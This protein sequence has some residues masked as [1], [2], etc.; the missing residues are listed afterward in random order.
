MLNKCEANVSKV[1]SYGA[2]SRVMGEGIGV[3]MAKQKPVLEEIS[4]S[5]SDG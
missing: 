3:L 4:T 1:R 5:F 2:Y